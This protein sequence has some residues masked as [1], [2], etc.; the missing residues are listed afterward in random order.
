MVI[1]WIW[2]VIRFEWRLLYLLSRFNRFTWHRW[3]EKRV[4]DSLIFRL[5]AA[6]RF[7]I[8]R[9]LFTCLPL[10]TNVLLNNLGL[11]WNESAVTP[12][13]ICQLC[14]DIAALQTC[15]FPSGRVAN[16]YVSAIF[17]SCR[18]YSAEIICGLKF[19]HS[20]GIIY[21]S[22][23]KKH[24]THRCTLHTY[25]IILA[26]LA[27]TLKVLKPSH[28]SWSFLSS[29]LKDHW[30]QFICKWNVKWTCKDLLE[31]LVL[32]FVILW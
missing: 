28:Y 30:F 26:S 5:T 1:H 8:M 24:F 20:K 14:T 15:S 22:E 23:H 32:C 10:H 11:H 6:L 18:F 7:H 25:M 4:R 12:A 17:V 27:H 29:C 16:M 19:L 21:R 31:L 13:F 2:P 3:Q 9:A